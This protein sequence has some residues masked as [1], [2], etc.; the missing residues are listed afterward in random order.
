MDANRVLTIALYQAREEVGQLV[1]EKT[2]LLQGALGIRGECSQIRR[3][4]QQEELEITRHL[5][6]DQKVSGESEQEAAEEDNPTKTSDTPGLDAL[7]GE[8]AALRGRWEGCKAGVRRQ[9]S[10]AATMRTELE[11]LWELKKAEEE[12]LRALWQSQLHSHSV[13]Q[14]SA[15]AQE[16]LAAQVEELKG[17]L[18]A[19]TNL[20]RRVKADAEA[21]IKAKHGWALRLRVRCLRFLGRSGVRRLAL[22]KAFWA[23]C[24]GFCDA[25]WAG[26]LQRVGSTWVPM[27]AATFEACDTN[28]DGVIDLAE[29]ERAAKEGDLTQG[30][31]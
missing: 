10:A 25:C 21:V 11:A 20:V 13:G 14:E 19:A 16:G 31:E 3:E 27:N 22:G 18:G 30:L 8:V 26:E 15:E 6:S 9:G 28:G 23:M 4:M 29:W 5:G 17:E 24:Q 1:G 2:A 7:R 12:E